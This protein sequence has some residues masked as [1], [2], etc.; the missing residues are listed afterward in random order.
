[1]IDCSPEDGCPKLRKVE[2]DNGEKLDKKL[3]KVTYYTEKDIKRGWMKWWG[4]YAI[5]ILIAIAGNYWY[6]SAKASS[7]DNVKED[8]QEIKD[9]KK[10]IEGQVQENSKQIAIIAS[11][12][13]IILAALDKNNK[14]L[15]EQNK[16]NR[17]KRRQEDTND[18]S[19]SEALP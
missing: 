7:V 13:D 19:D 9:D 3:D 11:K 5:V 16:I 4:G 1:M 12:A 17:V 8:V 18:S 6:T 14:L 2:K 15:E 10:K